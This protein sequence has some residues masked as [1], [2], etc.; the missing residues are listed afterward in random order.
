MDVLAGLFPLARNAPDT[1]EQVVALLLLS[2]LHSWAAVYLAKFNLPP[3]A[4]QLDPLAR[5]LVWPLGW[6]L[7]L[8]FLTSSPLW[9]QFGLFVQPESSSRLSKVGLSS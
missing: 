5:R 4:S 9:L 2:P 3:P 1:T 7:W 6:L 8:C